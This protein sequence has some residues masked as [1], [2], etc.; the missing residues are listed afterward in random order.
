MLSEYHKESIFA[1]M[2]LLRQIGY[3]LH[4]ELLM[5]LRSSY[6]ISGIL[7]YVF[8]T[9]FV[10][11]RVFIRLEPN[12]W[13]AMFWIVLLFASVN[14]VVKS[15][16]Q[17]SGTRQLYYYTL[18]NP[19]AVVLSKMIYNA[20][21]LTIISLLVWL[22]F[23][24]LGDSPVRETGMFLLAILLGSLGFSITFTFIS[25]IS[26]KA[27]NSATLMAIL[28]FPLVIPILMTVLKLTAGALRLMRDTAINQD[29]LILLGI[30]LLLIAMAIVLYPFLW[31]D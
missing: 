3:L 7:L 14:A 30:D 9:V 29:I 31:R 26:V 5:E 25:A 4:K 6:A 15:F 13:N 20:T 12:A 18:M 23:S 1:I 16:V 8:A 10:V 17:E 27:D 21:L 2:M 11:Y 28:S 19:L 22:G 24:F